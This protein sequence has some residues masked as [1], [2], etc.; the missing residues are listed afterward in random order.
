M[1]NDIVTT[2][3][4]VEDEDSLPQYTKSA[5]KRFVADMQTAGLEVEH[6][7]G[8]YFWEGPAVRVRDLQDAL[9]ETRVKCQWDQ[10]GRG[11]IVYPV[12]NS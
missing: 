5:H 6:Y 3:E 8:R 11:Y 12:V 4:D 9:S 7:H 2:I 1:M 10:M